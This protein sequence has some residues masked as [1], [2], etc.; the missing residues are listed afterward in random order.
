MAGT[1]RAAGPRGRTAA[2]LTLVTVAI[3]CDLA[4]AAL[5]VAVWTSR[6]GDDAVAT[7]ELLGASAVAGVI[8]L[9]VVLVPL[10]RQR[11]GPARAA[12]RLAWLRLAA[13]LG[14]VLGILIAAGTSALTSPV[15]A[16]AVAVAV[17]DAVAAILIAGAARRPHG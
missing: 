12:W 4:L 1:R 9:L 7:L 15:S 6:R 5:G 11:P 14:A 16:F 2:V 13:L 8:V 10:I 3:V 17:L